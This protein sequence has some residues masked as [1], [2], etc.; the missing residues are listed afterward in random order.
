VLTP[1]SGMIVRTT[2]RCIRTHWSPWNLSRKFTIQ[3]GQNQSVWVDIYIPKTAAPGVYQG[4]VK[5]LESGSVSRQVPVQLTVFNFQLPDQPTSKTVTYLDTTD[6]MWRYAAG[7]GGY[8]NWASDAGRK[9]QA[10]TDKYYQLF[11]RH[12]LSLMGENESPNVDKPADSSISRLDGS[13]YTAANG[14]DGPGVGSPNDVFG[15]GI[16]GTWNFKNDQNA[17]LTTPTTGHRGLNRTCRIISIS[18]ISRM[19]LVKRIGPQLTS[20]P[21]GH[22]RIPAPGRTSRHF[23][24]SQPCMRNNSFRTCVFPRQQLV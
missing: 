18:F 19:S 7:H 3:Q 11:H 13:L 17:F 4:T 24:P 8:V 6:I 22:N 5:V 9:V 21:L 2:T 14:Y 10:V 15:I 12:K 16:Y 23:V 20:G 1:N